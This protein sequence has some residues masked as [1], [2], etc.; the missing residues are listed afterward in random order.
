MSR[1]AENWST[2]Q[3]SVQEAILYGISGTIEMR[4]ELRHAD[5]FP[6]GTYSSNLG[7][8]RNLIRYRAFSEDPIGP[9]DKMQD[10]GIPP[11]GTP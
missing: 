4:M 9:S 8:A 1:V 11:K 3:D 7:N 10:C 6:I 2:L 5:L